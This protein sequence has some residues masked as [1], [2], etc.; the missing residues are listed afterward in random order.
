MRH[1]LQTLP[2]RVGFVYFLYLRD[3][4][5]ALGK[6]CLPRWYVVVQGTGAIV[7]LPDTAIFS[8]QVSCVPEVAL[9]YPGGLKASGIENEMMD[10][11]LLPFPPRRRSVRALEIDETI[12]VEH[13]HFPEANQCSSSV[14]GLMIPLPQG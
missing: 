4:L 6:P 11:R 14:L 9:R 13:T 10:V 5:A 7:H 3:N 1:A 2:C 12:G 8:S